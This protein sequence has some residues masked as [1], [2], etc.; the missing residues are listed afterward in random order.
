MI[1]A[2]RQREPGH[3]LREERRA[4]RRPARSAR[5]SRAALAARW[6]CPGGRSGASA[7][8][9]AASRTCAL[10]ADAAVAVRRVGARAQRRRIDRG[11]L[12][13]EIDAVEQRPRDA[14]AITGDPVRRA[15][16]APARMPEPSAR[17]RDS[18]RRRTGIARGTCSAAPRARC[19]RRPIRAA[20]A[21]RRGRDDPIRAARRGTARRG[22]RA[23]S[24]RAADPTRRR[25][26][27]PRS[28]C[29]AAP[30]RAASPSS[31]RRTVPRA[32][33]SP[34]S[35]APRPRSAAEGFREA[36]APAST[37]PFRAGRS[38]A[39]CGRRLQR[40]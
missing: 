9:V 12:D 24:R 26:V 15:M 37:C 39:G 13:A 10:D 32:R 38:S 36:A 30:G 35:R 17:A 25:P 33:R 34:R 22:A 18:S 4:G 2:R 8:A 29:G 40:W 20:R 14:A 16:T 31:L 27:R 7:R 3:R 5:R 21:A 19:A 28:P 11:H 6:V 1:R 23:R